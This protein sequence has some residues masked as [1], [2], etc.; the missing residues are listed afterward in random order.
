VIT[1][2]QELL[3]SP[4][5]RI[6]L[7]VEALMLVLGV[8]LLVRDVRLGL[9]RFLGLAPARL[10]A[11]PYRASEIFLAAALAFGGAMILQ[12]V[13]SLLIA[14]YNF[15]E[16]EGKVGLRQVM[17]SAAFHLGLLAGLS[18][19]WLWHVRFG[20][21]TRDAAL[22]AITAD[23]P[24]L[25]PSAAVRAGVITFLQALPIIALTSYA[26]QTLFDSLGIE[27]KPQ[28][29]I[30]LFVH[31]QNLPS[32]ILLI[33]LAVLVAPITEELVFRVGF[34]GWLRTRTLR[35]VALLV[36]AF[37]FAAL[38]SNLLVFFPLVS[39]AIVLSLAYEQTG[40]PLTN[41]VAHS[42]FN[43]NTVLL[44]LLGYPA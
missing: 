13:A 15:P 33:V 3:L 27:A 34:F 10:R 25:S 1:P 20:T 19:F 18:Y 5:L 30:S 31:N 6:T 36:P 44:V 16:P 14:H 29:L 42:L 17:Q 21:N 26:A 9:N 40:H 37:V 32:L 38:H 43:L 11:S 39:L 22:P 24:P 2:A 23:L 35:G 12:A 7:I 41:I 28:D 4:A 8:F